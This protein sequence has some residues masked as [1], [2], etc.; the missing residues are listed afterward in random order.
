METIVLYPFRWPRTTAATRSMRSAAVAK[1]RL[2][3]TLPGNRTPSAP[4]PSDPD[5][6]LRYLL[7]QD[8]HPQQ[9]RPT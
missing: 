4:R 9:R 8:P 5:T 2:H 3:D 6:L 1:R 7:Q